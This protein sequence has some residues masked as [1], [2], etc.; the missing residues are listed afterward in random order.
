MNDEKNESLKLFAYI[1]FCMI[2]LSFAYYVHINKTMEVNG[3]EFPTRIYEKGAE[4][5]EGAPGFIVCSIDDNK[6][7]TFKGLP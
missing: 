6:C 2:V 5:S 1:A 4:I 7:I 3:M